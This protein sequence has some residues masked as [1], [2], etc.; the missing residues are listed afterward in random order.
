MKILMRVGTPKHVHVFKNMIQNLEKDGHII[1]IS[2]KDEE[3]TLHLLKMYGLDYEKAGKHTAGLFWKTVNMYKTCYGL[4]KTAKNFKP[5]L[6]VS[7]GSPPTA[8]VSALIRKPHIAFEDTE[9]SIEQYLLYSPFT[10]TICTPD[11]FKRDLGKK[12]VRFHGYFELCYLHPN[13]FKP[14][15]SVLNELGL[16]KNDKFT[17][18]RFVAWEASHDIKQ[19]GFDLGTK[20]KL[21]RELEKYSKV[22][23]TSEK[24]LP[25]E[26]KRYRIHVAPEKI[27][28]LLSYATMYIG[29]GATMASES[30]VLGTPAIY[31]STLRL[32]Y[33]DEEEK[34]YGLVYNF[35]DP[36]TAGKQAFEKAIKLLENKNLKNEWGKKRER[37]LSEKI[38][39]TKWMTEFIENYPASFYERRII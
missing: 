2:A 9:H 14:D 12:Q 7:F 15:R 37:L 33:T 3:V 22:L 19:K 36:K 28:D 35:S 20:R 10:N 8:Q 25:K 16:S 27:H 6:L 4:Y 30:A 24:P 21:V 17:I 11:C 5:D 13:Y 1:K 23:I 29:E 34:R 31:V 26:F 32:G 18:I 39:V 38:D